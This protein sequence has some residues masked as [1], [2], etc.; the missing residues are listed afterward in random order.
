MTTK[1]NYSLK[2]RPDSDYALETML[3]RVRRR[4]NERAAI[5]QHRINQYT[6]MEWAEV[7]DGL[8]DD[9]I[10]AQLK[11]LTE[12]LKPLTSLFSEL[13]VSIDKAADN[14]KKSLGGN[15]E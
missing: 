15:S 4:T 12:A 2:P 13:G 1:Y 9:P 10:K 5:A 6:P 11:K 7:N 14:L 8:R 3:M